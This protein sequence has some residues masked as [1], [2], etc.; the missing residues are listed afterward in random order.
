MKSP[1]WILAL[2]LAGC[3]AGAPQVVIDAETSE[4]RVPKPARTVMLNDVSLPA[5][6]EANEITVRE[7]DGTLVE[8]KGQ[9]WADAPSRAMSNAMVRNLGTIT[10]AQVAAEPWPL[11]GYPEVEVT[12]RVEQMFAR[13]DGSISL[14]GY[15]AIRRDYG[16]S[17][18]QQFDI[19]LP[20]SPDAKA[21]L[22]RAYDA[23]WKT[24]A[25]QIARSL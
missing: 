20:G 25:E 10:G 16:R 7:D 22:P 6:A 14:T 9:V 13:A 1:I 2:V 11:E 5:Y 12:I 24:L 23:A 18:I 21:D 17:G 15:Y 4:L 8:I 3:G 19:A